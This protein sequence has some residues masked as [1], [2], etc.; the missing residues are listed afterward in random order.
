MLLGSIPWWNLARKTFMAS[1]ALGRIGQGTA[2]IGGGS[3]A[4][5]YMHWEGE[6]SIPTRLLEM[7]TAT[8]FPGPASLFR[9][10][11]AYHCPC[12]HPQRESSTGILTK[13][14]ME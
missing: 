11:S 9:P 4:E 14:K 6:T 7:I 10:M 1:S 5:V 12:S 2:K 8:C 3:Q 13:M